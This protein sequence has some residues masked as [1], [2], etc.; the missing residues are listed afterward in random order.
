M[1]TYT[2]TQKKMSIHFLFFIDHQ[3]PVII[4]NQWQRPL[5]FR[6]P[7]SVGADFDL[8]YDWS[9]QVSMKPRGSRQDDA[10]EI[11]EGTRSLSRRTRYLGAD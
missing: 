8:D 4:Q 2:I 5:G 6:T 10:E 1:L 3:P 9:L 7:E 11:A